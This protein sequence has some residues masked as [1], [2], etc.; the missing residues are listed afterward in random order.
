MG[1]WSKMFGEGLLQ[2]ILPVLD[3]LESGIRN[4][5]S[6]KE[7]VE[8]LRLVREQLMKVLAK[9]GLMEMKVIGEKFNPELHE[10]I[11]TVEAEKTEEGVVVAEVQKGYLLNG[12]VIRVA[13]V[14]VTK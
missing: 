2:D 5:E 6:G 13:K 14:K 4:Q 12:K 8:D 7:K 3:S 1:E 11:E 10:A 9:H